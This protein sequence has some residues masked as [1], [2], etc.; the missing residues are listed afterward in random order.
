MKLFRQFAWLAFHIPVLLYAQGTP[1]RGVAPNI[2]VDSDLVL[3]NALVT[4]R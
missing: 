2:K 3:V 1:I 4:D